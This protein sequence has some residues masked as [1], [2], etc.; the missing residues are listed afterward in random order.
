MENN[1]KPLLDIFG[2]L[3]TGLTIFLLITSIPI[4]YYFR[5]KYLQKLKEMIR[6]KEYVR[7]III[8]LAVTF[9]YV[10]NINLAAFKLGLTSDRFWNLKAYLSALFFIMTTLEFFIKKKKMWTE[11]KIKLKTYPFAVVFIS[12]WYLLGGITIGYFLAGE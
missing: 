9:A 12:V 4:L 8:F 10:A 1:F 11:V 2:Y 6:R 5:N 3:I 7:L